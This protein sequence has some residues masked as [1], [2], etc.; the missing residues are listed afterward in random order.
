[1]GGGGEGWGALSD[2]CSQR[3]RHTTR[4]KLRTRKNQDNHKEKENERDN[5]REKDNEKDKGNSEWFARSLLR[6]A[7]SF[8]L[9]AFSFL[10]CEI[11]VRS[12]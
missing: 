4:K 6:V 2:R 8:S 11:E 1:M 5:K 9:F 10:A 3:I 7:F 12:K